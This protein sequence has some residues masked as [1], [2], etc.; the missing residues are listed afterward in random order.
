MPVVKK[1]TPEGIQL[2]VIIQSD[3]FMVTHI[4]PLH[5]RSENHKLLFTSALMVFL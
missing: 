1:R 4:E 2:H 3:H 5:L